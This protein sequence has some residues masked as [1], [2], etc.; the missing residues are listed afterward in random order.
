MKQ[1]LLS[2]ACAKSILPNASQAVAETLS[3]MFSQA[4]DSSRIQNFINFS[5]LDSLDRL[6]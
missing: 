5:S 2:Q 6:H 4:T 1:R 3:T